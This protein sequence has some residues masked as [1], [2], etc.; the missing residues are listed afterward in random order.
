MKRALIIANKAGIGPPTMAVTV[1]DSITWDGDV[2]DQIP[3]EELESIVPNLR[4]PF[5]IK[6]T[7]RWE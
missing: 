3:V 7:L 1:H 2:L 5:E 6:Q 4:I